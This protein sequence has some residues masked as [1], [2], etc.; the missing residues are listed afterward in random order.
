MLFRSDYDDDDDDY[1]ESHS[2]YKEDDDE[3][4]KVQ[5]WGHGGINGWC[6]TGFGRS[7]ETAAYNMFEDYLRKNPSGRARLVLKTNG[8][9]VSVLGSN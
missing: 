6:D 7:S 1:E 8:K 5:F 9:V 2:R 3:E 4:Y